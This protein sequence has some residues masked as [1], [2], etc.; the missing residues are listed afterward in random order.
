MAVSNTLNAELDFYCKREK[1]EN[2]ILNNFLVL[3][4]SKFWSF[5]GKIYSLS[6]KLNLDLWINYMIQKFSIKSQ[7]GSVVDFEEWIW[8]VS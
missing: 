5:D 8:V 1:I 6:S 7:K 2:L 3:H 4:F